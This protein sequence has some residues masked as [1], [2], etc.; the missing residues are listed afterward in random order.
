LIALL[1]E[2]GIVPFHLWL[3]DVYKA[4]PLVVVLHIATIPK[5]AVSF[6]LWQLLQLY[7]EV[8]LSLNTLLLV[9][10]LL[11]LT[12]GSIFGL[13]QTNIKKIL[14][15]STVHHMGF[16]LLA[17]LMTTPETQNYMLIYLMAYVAASIIA[18]GALLNFQA[19]G[20]QTEN[21]T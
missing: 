9:L 14:A 5:F 2:L 6:A 3:P 7:P 19:L 4:A 8:V 12:V 13:S 21:I 16:V 18:F 20:Y 10:A 11:S 1:L 15:Y 17:I